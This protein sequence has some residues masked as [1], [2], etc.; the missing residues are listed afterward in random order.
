MLVKRFQSDIKDLEVTLEALRHN[1]H[2]RFSAETLQKP[3]TVDKNT[4]RDI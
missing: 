1:L 2:I 3:R 4:L